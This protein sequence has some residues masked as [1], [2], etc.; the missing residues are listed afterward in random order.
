M[1]HK[2]KLQRRAGGLGEVAKAACAG[3]GHVFLVWRK[4]G[5]KGSSLPY[6][7]TFSICLGFFL[8]GLNVGV[9]TSLSTH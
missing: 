5:E 9:T 6:A 1:N 7:L 2:L 3:D 4:D 8:L